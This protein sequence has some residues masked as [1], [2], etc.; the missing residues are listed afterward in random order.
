MDLAWSSV[1]RMVITDTPALV[2]LDACP[3]CVVGKTVYLPHKEGCGRHPSI[4]SVCML[5]L[6]D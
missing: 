4:W 6:W 5:I 3:V 1:S 2:L